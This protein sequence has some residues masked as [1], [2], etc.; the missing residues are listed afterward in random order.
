M[1]KTIFSAL[2]NP[3]YRIYFAGQ[4]LSMS[5][6]WMQS[7][8]QGWLVYRLSN[9]S[10]WLGLITF[11]TQFP[12]FL[13]TPVAGVVADLRNRRKLLMLV[14]FLSM[15]QA[16]ILTALVY[17]HTIQL[18]HVACLCIFL[19]LLNAFDIVTRHTF[20][21]DMVDKKDLASG[22]ALNAMIINGSR[23]LGPAIAGLLIGMF[24][25]EVCFLLNAISYLAVIYSLSKMK[26]AIKHKPSPRPESF[27]AEYKKALDYVKTSEITMQ[28]LMLSTFMSLVCFC[29]LAMLPVF[30]KQILLG[31]SYTLAILT[32]ANGLGALMGS[33]SIETSMNPQKMLPRL[34]N[35]L[36]LIGMSL[37]LF[38]YS[39]E[40]FLSALSIF[41]IGYCLMRA[42]PM[43]NV[44]IQQ[45]VSDELRGRV[46]SL[47]T[48]T[49]LAATPIGNLIAGYMSD[50]HGADFIVT[51]SGTICIGAAFLYLILNKIFK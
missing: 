25:E 8:A 16:L 40:L 39:D 29:Y 2:K 28:I 37:V 11:L 48:M 17:T 7:V 41:C 12:S 45:T 13:I 1:P 32:C 20:V 35:N 30:A 36:L 33:L 23:I 22:I 27:I 24:S 5:G 31:S 19:G 10:F 6:T 9:S 43:M 49:F 15:I 51:T 42:F 18:W 3:S 26:G 38:G 21:S 44:T 34:N 4:L 50:F 47:Y 14:A 46:L